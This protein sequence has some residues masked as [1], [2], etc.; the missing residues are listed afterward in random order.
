MRKIVACILMLPS[1]ALAKDIIVKVR[2]NPPSYRI[3]SIE[4]QP[5]PPNYVCDAPTDK[6]QLQDL[7]AAQ[8]ETD[9][10]TVVRD[11]SRPGGFRGAI[12]TAKQTARRAE[13]A[14]QLAAEKSRESM[15]AE[16]LTL[17]SGLIQKFDSG[18]DTVQDMRNAV[19]AC[20]KELRRD[21][22]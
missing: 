21:L 6:A 17:I 10:L 12:D 13:I 2:E 20:L 5:N 22:D 8:A 3:M 11:V 1:I 14:S 15:R 7:L 16:R 4:G 19:R 9:S 18:S